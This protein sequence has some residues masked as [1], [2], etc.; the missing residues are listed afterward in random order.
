MRT[1]TVLAGLA[2]GF[3]PGMP[4][5]AQDIPFV[6]TVEHTGADCAPPVLPEFDELPTIRPLPEPFASSDGSGR[7][8][9]FADWRCRRAEI[10]AEL[11]HYEI[12]ATPVRPD[13]IEASSADGVLTVKCCVCA[14]TAEAW[15]HSATA[16]AIDV[17]IIS[18]P[19]ARASGRA[20]CDPCSPS[21]Q[22]RADCLADSDEP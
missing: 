4:C 15:R 10:V 20:R 3:A 14:L 16:V 5:S 21:V 7:S 12:G 11:Q 19:P 13:N 17:R 6:Y 18:T 1:T 8:T 2:L 9:E 22:R